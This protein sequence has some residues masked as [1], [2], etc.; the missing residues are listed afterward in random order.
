MK[1]ALF[2]TL[3]VGDTTTTTEDGERKIAAALIERGQMLKNKTEEYIKG[4]QNSGNAHLL[5][6]LEYELK[7]IT[8]LTNELKNPNL[9]HPT[10]VEWINY[11]HRI[12]EELMYYEHIVEEE[13]VSILRASQ[14]NELQQTIIQLLIVARNLVP[15]AQE[16]LHKHPHAKEAS[17]IRHQLKELEQLVSHLEN[18]HEI[19][20]LL[21]VE[22][23]LRRIDETL[24]RLLERIASKHSKTN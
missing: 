17:A 6:A 7:M 20:D 4:H 1:I 22:Q 24:G 8:E 23:R 21:K 12:E 16:A 3:L 2:K 14:P 13:L 10:Y 18:H 19:H 5:S 9:T 11:V 15:Q